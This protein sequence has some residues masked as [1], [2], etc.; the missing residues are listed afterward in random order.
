MTSNSKHFDGKW[1]RSSY[2]PNNQPK[3]P[4]PTKEYKDNWDRI[5][6]RKGNE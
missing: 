6:N 2:N 4:V 3:T 5:F 1:R